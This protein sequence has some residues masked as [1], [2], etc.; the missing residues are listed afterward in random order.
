MR[1]YRSKTVKRLVTHKLLERFRFD[2]ITATT[3]SDHRSAHLIGGW[4]ISSA[5]D[6]LMI[7]TLTVKSEPLY[8]WTVF[9][10]TRKN[11]QVVIHLQQTCSNAIPTTCQQDVFA[12]L[13]PSLLTSFQQLVDNLLQGCW[14][15]QTFYKLS[16][17]LV[18]V[19]QINKLLT[20]CEPVT[21]L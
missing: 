19:L 20:S 3:T 16:Q 8:S 7:R 6:W 9:L 12:L 1:Y 14:A 11:A 13:V 21:T 10:Y 15:Q 17:Q 4:D 2:S 5:Y 18:I